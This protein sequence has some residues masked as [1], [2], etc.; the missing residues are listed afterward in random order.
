M[1]MIP[2]QVQG[3]ENPG[4]ILATI[5]YGWE[6]M[7]FYRKWLGCWASNTDVLEFKGPALAP[8]TIQGDHAEAFV[9]LFRDMLRD[10]DYADRIARHYRQFKGKTVGK[11]VKRG[12]T[13]A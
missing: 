3:E 2:L 10:R 13:T 6:K 1:K 4:G 7:A 12:D 9:G 11:R 8:M 5:S